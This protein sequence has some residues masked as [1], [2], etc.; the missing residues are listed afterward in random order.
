MNWEIG[1][2]TIKA[3]SSYWEWVIEATPGHWQ[4]IS[5]ENEVSRK[6]RNLNKRHFSSAVK[7]KGKKITIQFPLIILVFS[8]PT[9]MQNSY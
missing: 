7:L 2:T 3:I 4:I 8:K 9:R 5:Q 1:G 6:M